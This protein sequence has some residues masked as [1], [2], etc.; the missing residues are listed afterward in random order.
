MKP[1]KR[2]IFKDDKEVEVLTRALVEYYYSK[3]WIETYDKD[4]AVAKRLI[5]RIGD[6]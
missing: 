5:W 4:A 6:L 2:L 1:V 3:T